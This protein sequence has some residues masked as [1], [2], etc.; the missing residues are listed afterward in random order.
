M[1]R[2]ELKRKTTMPCARKRIRAVNRKRMAKRRAKQF[3]VQA[4]L[5]RR[6]P[7]VACLAESSP[8][9]TF[10]PT[11]VVLALQV[12]VGMGS[13]ARPTVPHHVRSRGAG[14]LDDV[15]VPV[16]DQHHD[17]VHTQGNA[18]WERIGIDPWTVVEV[19]RRAVKS[20]GHV[21][22]GGLRL[23]V[24]DGSSGHVAGEVR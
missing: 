19:M 20:R 17:E 8:L 12:V 5:C 14:G 10:H 11:Q 3:G 7:C 1:K 22:R 21:D 13:G 2:T 16:C 23:E 4:E 9:F 6:S 18:F 24:G 15:T